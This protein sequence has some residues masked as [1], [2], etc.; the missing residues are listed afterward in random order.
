MYEDYEV[1]VKGLLEQGILSHRDFRTY[2]RL[3]QALTHSC[4][5]PTLMIYLRAN[6]AT[7][8]KRINGRSRP[9]ERQ[10]PVSYLEHLNRRYEEWLRRFDLCPVV[11]IDT[12]DLDVVNVAEHRQQIVDTVRHVLGM[13]AD[14]EMQLNLPGIDRAALIGG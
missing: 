7:L 8:C 14:T 1:F 4:A 5:P 11:P 9:S 3:Y 12:D 10:I 6:V 13:R 2:R